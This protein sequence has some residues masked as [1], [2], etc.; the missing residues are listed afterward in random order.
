MIALQHLFR[1]SMS[2]EKSNLFLTSSAASRHVG[3]TAN[4]HV[5]K[6]GTK[7]GHHAEVTPKALFTQTVVLRFL[8]RPTDFAR[9]SDQF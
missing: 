9:L 1:S 3:P 7:E 2:D 6:A 5:E 8:S 4:G